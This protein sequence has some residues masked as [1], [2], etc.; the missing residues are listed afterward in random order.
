M[1]LITR[2][3]TTDALGN[4]G[5]VRRLWDAFESGG[6]ARM[7]EL[8]PPD[9]TWRPLEADGHALEGTDGLDAFW[10]AREVEMPSLRMFHGNG[11][12][13]LV[14]AEYRHDGETVTTVWLLY[15]FQ[16]QRLIEAIGF[17]T[18]AQARDYRPPPT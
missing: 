9:V 13:V 12:D 2:R 11:D 10:S 3:M 4:I 5:Y 16:G 15:R 1:G 17:P 7:A 14:E 6:V 8:I 18:E